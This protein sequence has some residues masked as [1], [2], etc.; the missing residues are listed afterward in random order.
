MRKRITSLLLTLAMMFSLV[1]ALGV[2]A[3]AAEVPEITSGGTYVENP[4]WSSV[5]NHSGNRLG[6]AS[7]KGL[8]EAPSENAMYIRL[9]SDLKY[10]GD[11]EQSLQISVRGVKHLDLN[12]HDLIYGSDLEWGG[13]FI[14]V[15]E[16][17]E[18]HIYDSRGGG[19]V[20]YEGYIKDNAEP[21]VRTLIQ[22]R[23]GGKLF[24][25]GGTFTAG[26]SKEIWGIWEHYENWRNDTYTGNIRNQITGDAI[27]LCG[28]S[29][30]VINGGSFHGRGV[31]Y[32]A[33][34]AINAKLIINGGYFKGYG[35]ADG[36]Q[37]GARTNFD[38]TSEGACII[39]AGEFDTHKL[40]RVY[41]DTGIYDGGGKFRY[42]EYGFAIDNTYW[43]QTEEDYYG[44]PIEIQ[45][46]PNAE[47]IVSG[48]G[49]EERQTITVKPKEGTFK[50]S[51]PGWDTYSPDIAFGGSEITR[52]VSIDSD[53]F[54]PYFKGQEKW[55]AQDYNDKTLYYTAAIWQIFD[56]D[57]NAVSNEQMF[58]GSGGFDTLPKS[59]DMRQFKATNGKDRLQL[60]AGQSYIL[61]CTLMEVWDGDP[62]PEAAIF[63][64]EYRFTASAF[65]RSYIKYNITDMKQKL[66]YPKFAL[67]LTSK[68]HNSG[69][70]GTYSNPRY[71][72]GYQDDSG[73]R[74]LVSSAYD[75]IR[76]LM[77]DLPEG[78]Q[79]VMGCFEV[80]DDTGMKHR[81]FDSRNVFVMPRIRGGYERN[82]GTPDYQ[83]YDNN[84][85][86]VEP[87]DYM[88][89]YPGIRLQAV[90]GEQL[91]TAGLTFR[92][93]HWQRQN[94]TT[95]VW[96]DI[97]SDTLG[98]RPDTGNGT[99]LLPESRSGT[100][101]A[102]VTY[103]GTWYSTSFTV[104]GSDYSSSQRVKVTLDHNS[105][106]YHKDKSSTITI[107][108][109]YGSGDWGT[110]WRPYF[111]IYKWNVPETFYDR[112]KSLNSTEQLSDGGL[113]LPLNGTRPNSGDHEIYSNKVTSAIPPISESVV[114]GK[115][116]FIPYVKIY[117]GDSTIIRDFQGDS[118]TLNILRRMTGFDITAYGENVTNSGGTTPENAPKVVMREE[119]NKMNLG[120]VCIPG[121]ANEFAKGGEITWSSWNKDVATVTDD[122]VVTAHRPGTALIG[123]SYE[124]TFPTPTGSET[125][126]IVRYI[127][128]VVPIAEVE[129]ADTNW[130]ALVGTKYN[131]VK[132]NVT[133]VRSCN[134]QWQ[135]AG[136]Y[137]ESKVTGLSRYGYVS[138]N[139]EPTDT[140]AYN[141]SCYVHFALTAKP[142]YQF[143]LKPSNLAGTEFIA[144]DL[145]LKI[146]RP[147]SDT[148]DTAIKNGYSAIN[149]NGYRWSPEDDAYGQ[150]YQAHICGIYV[151]EAIPCILDPNAVYLDTVAIETAE[152]RDGD[153]RYSGKIPTD[154]AGWDALGRNMDMM[155][156]RVLTMF[157]QKTADG[158]DLFGSN[159]QVFQLTQRLIGSGESY[160]PLA[161]GEYANSGYGNEMLENVYCLNWIDGKLVLDREKLKNARYTYG[162][163][164]HK[165]EIYGGRTG[166]DGKTY[167]FSPDVRV[168]VN[169]KEVQVVTPEGENGYGTN[170]LTISYYYTI[171]DPRPAI[172]NGTVSGLAAPVTGA[173]PQT[174]DQ[175]TVTGTN[176]E[177]ETNDK[178]YV[179]GLIWFIDENGNNTLDE[180]EECTP[181]NGLSQDGRFLG[182]KAYS[183]YLV[184][185]I[186][187]EDGRIN[188]SAFTLNLAG[189][190]NPIS[191]SQARGVYTFPETEIVGYG[192]S[193]K[194]KSYNPGNATT[195]QLMRG[196][197]EQYKTTIPAATGSGQV[198]QDFNLDTVA[199]GTYDLVVTKP[200][201]LTYTVKGVVVGDGPLDLTTMTGK[202]YSTITLLCGDIAKNGYID[203]ADYQELLSPANYGKKTTDTGVNEL[204]DLN[205]NGYIDFADYQI[206]LSSQHYGKS[207]VTVDFAE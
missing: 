27:Y 189:V 140:I 81:F 146:A 65:D 63:T 128:V 133:R 162:T 70:T 104:E 58:M 29:E 102:Y 47:V 129:I 183:A 78:K 166:A 178:M 115:Y 20:H 113:L 126:E 163:Y 77:T 202:P 141:D 164:G 127:R 168:L 52:M 193:G 82:E 40:D 1:P 169:G 131:Q 119:S 75:Y 11:P 89:N 18:L 10:V 91:S 185:T 204:A 198:T 108:P 45:Y 110:K 184:L 105:M 95:G 74:P 2:A 13:K 76:V 66:D 83:L 118:F 35:G 55:L 159:S 130:D 97:Q 194:V 64:A 39:N 134:G 195:I 172:V 79:V 180:G 106:E 171:N 33:I 16:G 191:T 167:Y 28:G 8:M 203:F 161:E 56:N 206:L 60:T 22:V 179:S 37:I 51:N 84:T 14:T 109:N 155:N 123:M 174:G 101:R 165:L 21:G 86:Q 93:V 4:T 53:S 25:N 99:L 43:N 205:G 87:I 144:N 151:S 175:L 177:Y 88:G 12:G 80:Q 73:W 150:D 3:G 61:R 196:G 30:C 57:G 67:E 154:E 192:V 147:G 121:D 112:V 197:V 15:A 92:D 46:N 5:D 111:L 122:G 100:Y 143:P 9:D 125:T 120:Y 69:I 49:K 26:R 137:V 117:N 68:A 148:A 23:E 145:T 142:G 71:S 42:G 149:R 44:P 36:L 31:G 170:K 107:T 98:A 85:F 153:L 38:G 188:Y 182:G 32:G 176:T 54:T 152:P 62:S 6:I 160:T 41:Y 138:F 124:Y 132:L 200:G 186:E 157:G 187:P 34:T 136:N 24:V 114:P 19:Y 72:Y 96:E 50:L 156:V 181:G 17:A 139:K 59:V 48:E 199:A 207:T 90:T 116:T 190:T 201:H 173:M 94:E 7:L 135:P 103:Y 158:G